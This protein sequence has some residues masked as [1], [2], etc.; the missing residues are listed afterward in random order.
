MEELIIVAG[1]NKPAVGQLRRRL[2]E[3]GY[4]SIPCEDIPGVMEELDVLPTCDAQVKMVVVEDVLLKE[5]NEETIEELSGYLPQAPVLVFGREKDEPQVKELL[6]EICRG[7]AEF[8]YG[9]TA[10]TGVLEQEGVSVSC[11]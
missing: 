10:L 6:R 2:R 1:R 3:Q 9:E 8:D 5:I 7:R 4:D 11:I